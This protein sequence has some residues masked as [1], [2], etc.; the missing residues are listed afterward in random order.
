MRPEATPGCGRPA[1][2]DSPRP[3]FCSD[4]GEFSSHDG[5][6]YCSDPRPS[7]EK[8]TSLST[9]PSDRR[10]AAENAL[11]YALNERRDQIYRAGLSFSERQ[12][13]WMQEA[14]DGGTLI[15]S[16]CTAME[17]YDGHGDPDYLSA[18]ARQIKNGLPTW[19]DILTTW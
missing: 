1:V 12:H 10:R 4:C 8:K 17:S 16:M 14:Y 3:L 13:H 11:W 5:L 7:D 15:A 2:V 9:S 19:E 6:T 18:M